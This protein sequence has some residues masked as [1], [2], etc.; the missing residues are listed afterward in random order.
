MASLR[1]WRHSKITGLWVVE[2]SVTSE[3]AIEW[4]KIFQKFQ[5]AETFVISAKRPPYPKFKF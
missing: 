2:R 5:P 4:L 1:L 3:T